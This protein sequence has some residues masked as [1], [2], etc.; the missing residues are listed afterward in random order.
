M[1]C[2]KQGENR[3]NIEHF[4]K[5]INFKIFFKMTIEGKFK[6]KLQ[7]VIFSQTDH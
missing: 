6:Q 7:K 2:Y 3:S 1:K 5:T 4:K